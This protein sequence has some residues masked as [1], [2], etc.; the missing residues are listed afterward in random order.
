MPTLLGTSGTDT[1]TGTTGADTMAGGGGDDT[2]VVDNVGDVVTEGAFAAGT[3]LVQ[4]SISYTLTAN[5]ENLTLTGS[6]NINAT[7]NSLGNIIVQKILDNI[8]I[9]G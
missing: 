7:G 4:A 3:D 8:L 6:S 5:V 9:Q 2:Y 1:I